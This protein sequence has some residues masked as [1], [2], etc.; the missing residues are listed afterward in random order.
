MDVIWLY[1]LNNVRTKAK[2]RKSLVAL[3]AHAQE[4]VRHI[5]K[6]KKEL[7]LAS[8]K[9]EGKKMSQ[10][11]VSI[12]LLIIRQGMFCLHSFI[13]RYY[14]TPFNNVSVVML[15]SSIFRL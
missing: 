4:G 6:G 9:R 11:L 13:L 5:S 10:L 7:H 3:T 1:H 14:S 12:G 8:L 15:I 2:Y